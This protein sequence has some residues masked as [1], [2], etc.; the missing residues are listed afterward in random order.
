MKEVL[1]LCLILLTFTGCQQIENRY[2]KPENSNINRTITA[3]ENIVIT[4]DIPSWNTNFSGTITISNN[5]DFAINNWN[6]EFDWDWNID[7]VWDCQIVSHIGNH[8]ILTNNVSNRKIPAKE[9]LVFGV[10]GTV[11]TKG[12][13]PENYIVTEASSVSGISLPEGPLGE[14]GMSHGVITESS[15]KFK[16]QL[17][18][19]N[20]NSEYTWNGSCFTVNRVEFETSSKIE[21]ITSPKGVIEFKQDGKKVIMDLGWLSIFN[22][23]SSLEINIEGE[24]DG[25]TALPEN[26]EVFY[27]RGANIIYPS[28]SSL[29]ASWSKGKSEVT[30]SDLI[31][32]TVSYYQAASDP[33]EDTFIMYNE[34]HSTQLL[35]GQVDRIDYPVNTV[36]GVRIHIP[37]V[38]MAMGLGIVYEFLSINPNYMAALGTKENFSAGIT[39]LSAG[40]LIN[41]IEIDGETWYWPIQKHVDGPYQ[42][43][44]GNFI[45]CAKNLPDWFPKNANHPDYTSISVD[46]ADPHWISAGFSSGLSITLTRETLSAATENYNEFIETAKDPNAEFGIVTFAYNRGISN[47]F[48]KKLFSDHMTEALVSDDIVDDFNMGGFAAHV[49]TVLLVT[50]HMNRNTTNIYDSEI[51]WDD[52]EVFFTQIRKF[53]QNGVPTDSQWNDMKSDVKKAFNVLK[54]HWGGETVSYRYDFLTLIRVMKAHI[55]S[56]VTPRPAG[57]DWYYLIKN[58]QL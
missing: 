54:E 48:T 51:S 47:F 10:T 18:L 31:S 41:P 17:L 29:P 2:L 14:L 32:D 4:Q 11:G 39:P 56:P 20:V 8:Y 12:N 49:P 24:K 9:S 13:T 23:N 34:P 33:V 40:F 3:I 7:N 28:K 19:G 5:N 35:I 30:E 42:Q 57:E 46:P 53:Y 50:E 37:G 22:L 25:D 21:Y 45:D 52:M 26:F 16:Y 1:K 15:E 55:P 44:V 38:Y 6:I 58:M 43:E 36:T 27:Q